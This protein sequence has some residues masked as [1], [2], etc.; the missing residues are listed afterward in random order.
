MSIKDIQRIGKLRELNN[1]NPRWVNRDLY[2]LLYKP[3]L[4]A[5]AYETL[6]SNAGNMTKGADG[7]TID[8]FSANQIGRI[9]ESMKDE[10][11]QFKPARRVEIPKPNGKKRPL[12][13]APPTDKVVQEVIKMIL[14]AIYE[15]TFSDKSHGFREGKGC[16]TALKEFRANWSGVSWII[17]G[18]IK[19]F[20]DNIDHD[21]LISLLRKRIKD[22]RFLNLVRKA[23]KAGYLEFGTFKNTIVGT[24]QGSVVSPILANIYLDAFDKFIESSVIEKNEKGTIKKVHP[25]LRSLQRKYRNRLKRASETEDEETKATLMAEAAEFKA[26]IPK[27]PKVLDDGSYIRVKY[28]RYA[29]D[30]IIGINGPRELAERVRQECADYLNDELKLELS[31]EKTHIRHAK[32]ERADFLGTGLKVGNTGEC[33]KATLTSKSGLKFQKSVTGWLPY[34]TAPIR[35]LVAR[36]ADERFCD[37]KGNPRSKGSWSQ[38]DDVQIV[39]LYGSVWRGIHNYYSFVDNRTELR[40]IQFILLY[41]A[42]KTLADKHRSSVAKMFKKHGKRLTIEV[43]NEESQIVKVISFPLETSLKRQPTAFLVGDKTVNGGG[44]MQ[45]HIRLRTRSKLFSPCCICGETE[46]IEMHHVRHVRKIGEKVKGFTKLMA[47]LNRKQIPVCQECHVKIHNGTYDGMKLNQF[48][49]P[50]LAKA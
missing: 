2:R 33:K 35:K 24:P 45:T 38:L 14:E 42:A 36:L 29:D 16:H 27:A 40:R 48:A 22:E 11:F 23:L 49:L 15:P 46:N 39:D 10:S 41:G 5:V 8:G 9:V 37:K 44:K 25:E 3:S 31:F 43:R 7:T 47:K 13:I 12:G 32:T 4:Y 18:D 17:E 34:M 50:N 21:I 28:I 20:F 1:G 19:G 26:E 6:K 30:W